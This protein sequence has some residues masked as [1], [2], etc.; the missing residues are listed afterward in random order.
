MMMTAR[1]LVVDCNADYS[2]PTIRIQAAD[3]ST[4]QATTRSKLVNSRTLAKFLAKQFGFD[5]NKLEVLVDNP[6]PQER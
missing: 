1:Y 5:E 3:G 4:Q 6:Q 2:M